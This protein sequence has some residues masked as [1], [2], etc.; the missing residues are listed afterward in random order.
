MQRPPAGI[1]PRRDGAVG[2]CLLIDSQ[3][4]QEKPRT[5]HHNP[6]VSLSLAHLGAVRLL[7]LLSLFLYDLTVYA[8]ES[9]S[10]GPVTGHSE[11]AAVGCTRERGRV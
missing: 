8:L 5:I 6:V 9:G 3:P 1:E 10:F 4:N 2:H 11:P 7:D